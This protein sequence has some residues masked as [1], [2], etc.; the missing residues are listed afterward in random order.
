MVTMQCPGC[1]H[2]KETLAGGS[3]W[4]CPKCDRELRREKLVPAKA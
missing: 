4:R 1:G 3:G 2:K